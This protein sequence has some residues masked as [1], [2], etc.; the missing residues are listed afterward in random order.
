MAPLFW[1][2]ELAARS[3]RQSLFR[4]LPFRLACSQTNV[5]L[6]SMV[7]DIWPCLPWLLGVISTFVLV[8][9][10]KFGFGGSHLP[11][12]ESVKSNE[13][14]NITIDQPSAAPLCYFQLFSIRSSYD[15]IVKC[16]RLISGQNST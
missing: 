7:Q 1:T 9:Q 12:L 15:L 3:K 16:H 6:S 2:K 14:H 4:H 8:P 10:L 5:M 13:N 11:W